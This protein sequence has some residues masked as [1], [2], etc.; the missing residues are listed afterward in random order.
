MKQ[1]SLAALVGFSAASLLHQRMLCSGS[2]KRTGEDDSSSHNILTKPILTT[3]PQ[4][5]H[6][7]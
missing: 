4:E 1:L 5:H 7:Y 6:G 3:I 2:L